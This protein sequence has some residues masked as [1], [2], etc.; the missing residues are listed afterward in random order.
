VAFA[1]CNRAGTY[2]RPDEPNLTLRGWIR[3]H[4]DRFGCACRTSTCSSRPAGVP[5][6]PRSPRHPSRFATF[7]SARGVRRTAARRVEKTRGPPWPPRRLL[8]GVAATPRRFGRESS[9]HDVQP[10]GR[11]TP[12]C[13]SRRSACFRDPGS[14]PADQPRGL[15]FTDRQPL[16][17]EHCPTIHSSGQAARQATA[18]PL[19]AF[20]SALLARALTFRFRARLLLL[21][22]RPGL[23]GTPSGGPLSGPVTISDQ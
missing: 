20:F 21:C 1:P 9:Y 22:P 4:P 17:R 13:L 2:H 12:V 7:Q 6:R 15:A 23:R 14:A 8:T 5:R 11:L 19:S 10:A 18:R 3:R 16:P